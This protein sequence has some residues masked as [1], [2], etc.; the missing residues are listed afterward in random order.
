MVLL[1]QESNNDLMAMT[2]NGCNLYATSPIVFRI[3]N[4]ILNIMQVK[5][6]F[7]LPVYYV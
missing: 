6:R 7:D 1:V 3:L 2:N 4:R 5:L